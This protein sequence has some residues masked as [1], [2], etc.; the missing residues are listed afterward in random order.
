MEYTREQVLDALYADVVRKAIALGNLDEP[1]EPERYARGLE[2][3]KAARV[4][5]TEA[6]TVPRLAD[7]RLWYEVSGEIVASDVISPIFVEQV[8]HIATAPAYFAAAL[9][10]RQYATAAE[11][12]VFTG[13][14]ESSWRNRAA[15]GQ[16]PGAVKRGK[17]WLIP[18]PQPG[19]EGSKCPG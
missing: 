16:I 7:G 17:T 18:W 4:V 15:V 5:V 3:L 13:T 11:A 8:G 10:P 9:I 6:T 19:H 14:S 1:E 12:A 2:V